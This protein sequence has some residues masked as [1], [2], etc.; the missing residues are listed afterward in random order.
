LVTVAVGP[1]QPEKGPSGNYLLVDSET[2]F[3]WE[4]TSMAWSRNVEISCDAEWKAIPDVP[5][6]FLSADSN[7]LK[8]Q[9][10]EN[11]D[12]DGRKGTINLISGTVAAQIIVMQGG[13]QE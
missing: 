3:K 2:E 10:L 1:G 8:I 13:Q 11:L 12:N 9:L 5:W 4:T 7:R 6:I